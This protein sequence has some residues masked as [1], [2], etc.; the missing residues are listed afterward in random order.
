[1]DSRFRG[2]DTYLNIYSGVAPSLLFSKKEGETKMTVEGALEQLVDEGCDKIKHEKEE[3]IQKE[4][5]KRI[6]RTIEKTC[7]AKDLSEL[8]YLIR[9]REKLGK[10]R[11][12][13]LMGWLDRLN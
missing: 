11:Y 12:N 13:K 8:P 9:V 3:V 7:I 1:M 5:F 2:N 10:E 4:Y 6:V